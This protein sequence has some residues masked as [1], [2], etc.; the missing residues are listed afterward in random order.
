MHGMERAPAAHVEQIVIG[1]EG[2]L[3]SNPFLINIAAAPTRVHCQC[4]NFFFARR[5]GKISRL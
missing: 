4:R 2:A 1:G 5:K 3:I